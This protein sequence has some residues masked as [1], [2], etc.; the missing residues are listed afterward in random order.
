MSTGLRNITMEEC[1][2]AASMGA[3]SRLLRS[4]FVPALAAATWGCST[5]AG[6]TGVGSSVQSGEEWAFGLLAR[7]ALGWAEKVDQ[8]TPW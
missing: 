7:V 5:Q 2:G 4:S 1:A 8:G 3:S 6:P